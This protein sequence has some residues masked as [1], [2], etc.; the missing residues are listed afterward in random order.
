MQKYTTWSKN[1]CLDKIYFKLH[2]LWN[3]LTLYEVLSLFHL[4]LGS[5]E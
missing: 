1:F 4:F 2:L 5:E 3:T